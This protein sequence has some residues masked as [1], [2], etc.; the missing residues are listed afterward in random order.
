MEFDQ[1]TRKIQRPLF[2]I[3]HPLDA[4]VFFSILKNNIHFH[5][6]NLF[7]SYSNPHWHS[8]EAESEFKILSKR[9]PIHHHD[10]CTNPPKPPPSRLQFLFIIKKSFQQENEKNI[11]DVLC[12][13]DEGRRLHVRQCERKRIIC[14][15][16]VSKE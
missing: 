12:I 14:C 9:L 1:N 15:A 13:T 3:G 16:E 2:I 5:S 8:P 11:V 7:R 6:K 4:I 10:P